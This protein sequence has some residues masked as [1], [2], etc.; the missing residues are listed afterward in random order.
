MKPIL[1]NPNLC[2]HLKSGE[3]ATTF[4][5]DRETHLRPIFSLDTS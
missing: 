4:T 2:I 1:R 5:P 3:D